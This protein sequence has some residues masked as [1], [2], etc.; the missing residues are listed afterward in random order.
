MI[1]DV[2]S[3]RIRQEIVHQFLTAPSLPPPPPNIHRTV[4]YNR[5]VKFWLN[6]WI[7]MI[8]LKCPLK[9]QFSQPH[10]FSIG[11][12]IKLCFAIKE[13][14]KHKELIRN[15]YALQEMFI[16]FCFNHWNWLSWKFSILHFPQIKSFS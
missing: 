13:H 14:N 3:K 15:L 2:T 7:W 16:Q 9:H 4:L 11:W 5:K 1:N 6:T 12:F 8:I 10:H